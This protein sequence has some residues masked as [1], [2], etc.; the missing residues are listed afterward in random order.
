MSFHRD[1][2]GKPRVTIDQWLTILR[3]YAWFL[4]QEQNVFHGP[5]RHIGIDLSIMPE[6]FRRVRTEDG[7]IEPPW[8]ND[9]LT[10]RET[11]AHGLHLFS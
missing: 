1:H 11:M 8:R 2:A 5:A 4:D 10:D 9:G 6:N 7:R 3:Q